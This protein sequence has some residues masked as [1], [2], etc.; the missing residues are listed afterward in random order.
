MLLL[1]QD[2]KASDLDGTKPGEVDY[3]EDAGT[4][5]MTV[6]LPGR[7]LTKVTIN[8][9]KTQEKAV[10]IRAIYEHAVSL[11]PAFGPYARAYLDVFLHLVRYKY[12]SEIRGTSAHTLSAVFEAAC[13]FGDS[14]GMDCPAQYLPLVTKALAT[15]LVDEDDTDREVLYALSEALSDVLYCVFCRL[16]DHGA[17]LLSQYSIADSEAVVKFCMAALVDCLKRRSKITSI[18][19]GA[20]GAIAGEDE[21]ERCEQLL[22]E[23]EDLLTQSV[24]S[25]GYNLK[26]FR[27]EFVPI[28]ETNVAP[29]LSP[30]LN[31]GADIR[32]RVSA[33]CLFDDLVEY[34]GTAAASN[35]APLLAVGAVAGLD[36]ST[37]GSDTDLQRASIYG[38]SQIC[39]YAPSSVL[40]PY[41]RKIF[42]PLLS[43]VT[44]PKDA[45]DDRS[46]FEN[47]VSALAS[48]VLVGGSPFKDTKFVK[49]GTVVDIFLKSLPLVEDFDESKFCNVST[50]RPRVTSS[51]ISLLS[52]TYRLSSPVI[53]RPQCA[54]SS[55]RMRSH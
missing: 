8:T 40:K 9:S 11:G 2:A 54:I 27:H 41:E 35:V 33:V 42:P 16:E 44:Q 46:V 1:S 50:W 52:S 55:K 5:S 53:D 29:V 48:L 43:I 31:V 37:N 20:E 34:G 51:C 47:A 45:C 24:D 30:F 6:A 19:A 18:L 14:N 38:I 3:D 26:F 28:F 21:K 25:V 39:R 15:Q 17:S 13:S 10:A 49:V 4:E 22:L 7:G 12:S 36:D 32:A 23:E